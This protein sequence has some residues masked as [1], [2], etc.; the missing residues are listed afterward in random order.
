ML[1]LDSRNQDSVGVALS[2]VLWTN[3]AMYSNSLR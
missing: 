1:Y 3:V 2:D